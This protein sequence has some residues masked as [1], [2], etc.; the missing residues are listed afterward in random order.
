MKS[1]KYMRFCQ[2]ARRRELRDFFTKMQP[3]SWTGCV[4]ITSW[5]RPMISSTNWGLRNLTFANCKLFCN[6]WWFQYG[7]LCSFFIPVAFLFLVY[8]NH[9]FVLFDIHLSCLLWKHC[10]YLHS[11]DWYVRNGFPPRGNVLLSRGISLSVYHNHQSGLSDIHSSCLLC[12][13]CLYLP[14]NFWF[15]FCGNLYFVVVITSAIFALNIGT[16]MP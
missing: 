14:S 8:H 6:N 1:Y 15:C 11:N 5:A 4:T 2:Y 7:H 9:Q 3:E 13:H 16:S 10:L 12:K